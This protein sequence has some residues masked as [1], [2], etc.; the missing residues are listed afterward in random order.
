LKQCIKELLEINIG[1]TLHHIKTLTE[2]EPVSDHDGNV[3][4]W[5]F[6]EKGMDLLHGEPSN[7]SI[8]DLKNLISKP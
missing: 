2:H 1:I 4:D 3:V 6:I 7:N 8:V 5:T